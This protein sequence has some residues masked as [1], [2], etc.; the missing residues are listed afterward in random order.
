MFPD[1]LQHIFSESRSSFLCGN[2][3]FK[4]HAKNIATTLYQDDGVKFTV[5]KNM[6]FSTHAGCL[7]Q[8][9]E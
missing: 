3:F 6:N 9:D 8:V 2:P 4:I 7:S 5:N 1:L